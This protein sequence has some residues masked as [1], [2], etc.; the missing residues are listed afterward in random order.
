[1]NEA[2]YDLSSDQNNTLLDLNNSSDHTKAAFN[3]C[4][5]HLK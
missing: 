3:N 5:I 1:M 2:K 4:F